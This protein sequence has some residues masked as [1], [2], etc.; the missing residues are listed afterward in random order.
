MARSAE[1]RLPITVIASPIGL[2][3]EQRS[4][5]RSYRKQV[6]AGDLLD[7]DSSTVEGAI[8]NVRTA[9]NLGPDAQISG[10]RLVVPA[11]QELG[12]YE[13]RVR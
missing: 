11:I 3:I 10:F 12:A 9:S 1:S 4:G 13:G 6:A 5:L 8:P 2:E 7:V